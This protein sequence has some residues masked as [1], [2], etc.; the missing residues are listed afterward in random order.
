MEENAR[1][2]PRPPNIN[3]T[4]QFAL[5][6]TYKAESSTTIYPRER[7]EVWISMALVEVIVDRESMVSSLE[8]LAPAGHA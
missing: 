2:C 5:R 4:V 6:F 1:E 3:R 7:V 8:L